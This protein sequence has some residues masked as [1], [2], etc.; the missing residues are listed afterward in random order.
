MNDLVGHKFEQKRE[1][2]ASAVECYMK[3]YGVTEEEA[4]VELTK[5]VNDSWQDINEEWLD[6]TSIPRP[7]LLLILNFA[8]VGV[9]H[10]YLI[11]VDIL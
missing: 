6:A 1:H 3:Q 11:Y 8:R 4:E 5:Q 10:T 7:L 2:I 9:S